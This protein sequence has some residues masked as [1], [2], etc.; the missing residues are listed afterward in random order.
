MDP[1]ASCDEHWIDPFPFGELLAS[2]HFMDFLGF[3]ELLPTSSYPL[4]GQSRF[5][6]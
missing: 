3:K 1:M 6:D 2:F 5:S 4:P